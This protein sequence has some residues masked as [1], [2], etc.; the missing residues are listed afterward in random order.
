MRTSPTVGIDSSGSIGVS[1]DSGR[2]LSMAQPTNVVSSDSGRQLIAT[3]PIS[4]V[5]LEN[6]RQSSAVRPISGQAAYSQGRQL[7]YSSPQTSIGNR[8]G[9]TL[10]AVKFR[11]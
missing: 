11:V 6:G 1:L 7:P 3:Q 2:Q 5:S 8:D 10:P 4:G 9:G